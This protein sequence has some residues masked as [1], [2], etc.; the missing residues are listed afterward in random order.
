MA[1]LLIILL[2]TIVLGVSATVAGQ[3]WNVA[4]TDSRQD[5]GTR[6]SWLVDTCARSFLVVLLA[7]LGLL[8][9]GMTYGNVLG[10]AH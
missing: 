2:I 10:G 3:R 1:V 9:L 7:L 4:G 6:G 8:A 5:S